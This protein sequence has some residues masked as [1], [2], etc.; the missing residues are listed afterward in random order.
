MLPVARVA[1]W[2]RRACTL[3]VKTVCILKDTLGHSHYLVQA[4]ECREAGGGTLLSLTAGFPA[5]NLSISPLILS[6]G[7]SV[8]PPS[9][10]P[11]LSHPLYPS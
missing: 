1:T 4:E 10:R 3:P 6:L 2:P 7:Y 11:V 8:P 5:L 9:S